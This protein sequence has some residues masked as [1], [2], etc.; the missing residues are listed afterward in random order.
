M[1]EEY[2]VG[3][4]FLSE[5]S[6]LLSGGQNRGSGFRKL[7]L[8][9]GLTA[10]FTFITDGMEVPVPLIHLVAKQRRG[11]GKTWTKDVRCLKTKADDETYCPLCD[12]GFNDEGKPVYPGP[13]PRTIFYVFVDYIMHATKPEKS[14]YTV[15]AVSNGGVTVWRE[16]IGE[17]QLLIVKN[18]LNKQIE[19][20]FLGD[21]MDDA[22]ADRKPTLK[23]R[24]YRLKVTGAQ[25][26][27]QE[28][29]VPGT[30]FEKYPENVA[31]VAA[32]L[33][34]ISET[35]TAELDDDL[36][37]ALQPSEDNEGATSGETKT[38]EFELGDS[39]E[40]NF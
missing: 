25:S 19:D 2:G 27:R 8:R 36:L 26:D 38:E 22:F 30:L 40:I 6:A 12:A 37:R 33:A 31:E 3:I 21:P 13:W 4:A 29:L 39:D 28:I 11:G 35:V 23:D 10:Q 7:W 1:G 34:P 14:N 17:V 20:A 32:K 24:Q 18:K 5:Q 16:E 9:D 15:K